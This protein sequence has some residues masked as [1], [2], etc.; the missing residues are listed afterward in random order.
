[1]QTSVIHASILHASLAV[2]KNHEKII[3]T[4]RQN[5]GQNESNND[6]SKYHGE[7]ERD[8]HGDN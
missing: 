1:M 4:K 6:E 2:E 3:V 8:D 7:Y 5:H